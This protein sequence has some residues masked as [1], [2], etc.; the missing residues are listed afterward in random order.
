MVTRALNDNDVAVVTVLRALC[1]HFLQPHVASD[2]VA[3]MLRQIDALAP[4]AVA[5]VHAMLH[6]AC[7]CMG[8]VRPRFATVLEVATPSCLGSTQSMREFK[9][10]LIELEDFD[11]DPANC[12]IKV[13]LAVCATPVPMQAVYQA[14]ASVTNEDRGKAA[15]AIA[16]A[17]LHSYDT[18]HATLVQTSCPRTVQN[19]LAKYLRGD[20]VRLVCQYVAGGSAR[21]QPGV[22]QVAA[23]LSHLLVEHLIAQREQMRHSMRS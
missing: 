14:L 13:L 7:L 19:Y 12:T 3:A 8:I 4:V 5:T 1:A 9:R 20:E 11:E 6:T 10:S 23:V 15:E 2:R 21:M 18:W 16:R 17:V 22:A